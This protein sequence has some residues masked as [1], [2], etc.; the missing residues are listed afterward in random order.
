[1][2]NEDAAK[3]LESIAKR[4]DGAGAPS[5]WGGQP[6][7]L[8]AK[9]LAKEIRAVAADLRKTTPAAGSANVSPLVE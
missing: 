6:K 9:G 3:R 5:A 8:D 1:V 2:T 7:P 4:L